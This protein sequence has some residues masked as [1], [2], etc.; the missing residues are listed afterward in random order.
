[1]MSQPGAAPTLTTLQE[2]QIA[3]LEDSQVAM[4]P[5]SVGPGENEV[6]ASTKINW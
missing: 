1:M 5:F 3:S 2:L 6:P 4:L